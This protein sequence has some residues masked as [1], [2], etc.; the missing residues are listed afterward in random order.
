MLSEKKPTMLIKYY[1]VVDKNDG[2]VKE[3]TKICSC[4]PT[5]CTDNEAFGV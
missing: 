3:L 1:R 2:L 5:L 4:T